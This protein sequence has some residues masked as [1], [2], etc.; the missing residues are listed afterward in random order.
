MPNVCKISLSRDHPVPSRFAISR[1]Y[2]VPFTVVYCKLVKNSL[3]KLEYVKR[4]LKDYSIGNS[5][6]SISASSNLM[7]NIFALMDSLLFNEVK[8]N[9]VPRKFY[10]GGIVSEQGSYVHFGEMRGYR[11]KS[12]A[13]EIFNHTKGLDFIILS[14][15]TPD[16]GL[17]NYTYQINNGR[18]TNVKAKKNLRAAEEEELTKEAEA[19]DTEDAPPL[20]LK[21]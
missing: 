14:E 7:E 2:P 20:N 6:Y 5:F 1:G 9:C 18:L 13:Y 8:C 12:V 3:E 17:R 10:A 4:L 19:S 15:D 16:Q 21:R 11:S